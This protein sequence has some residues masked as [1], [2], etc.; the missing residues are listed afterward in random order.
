[1]FEMP[2]LISALAL[3]FTVLS[4]WWMNWRPG[5]LNVGNIRMFAAGVATE[6]SEHDV[7]I[8]TLPMNLWNSG[9]RPIVIDR[10]RLVSDDLPDLEF[11]GADSKLTTSDFEQEDK[12]ERDFYFL[13]KAL[14]PNEIVQANLVFEARGQQDFE[15]VANQYVIELEVD[16]MQRGNWKKV[17]SFTLDFSHAEPIHLYNLNHYYQVYLY[18]CPV[19]D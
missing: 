19:R 11:E 2:I 13:P 6:K 15:W 3:L 18:E 14:K 16:L 17:G 1:M 8:V 10:I 5:K 12:V 4:F 7:L 9:A